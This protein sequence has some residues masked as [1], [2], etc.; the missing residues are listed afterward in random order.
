MMKGDE[1]GLG[2]PIEGGYLFLM[3]C[4]FFVFDFA[5]TDATTVCA[6]HALRTC[7]HRFL[8]SVGF[9]SDRFNGVSDAAS[10]RAVA[11]LTK[12]DGFRGS[13]AIEPSDP[14]C[15]FYSALLRS[16]YKHQSFRSVLSSLILSSCEGEYGHI[17]PELSGDRVK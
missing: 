8:I 13:F 7:R 5:A 2:D 1:F 6:G 11:E 10:L 14:G 15:A 4:L 9:G 16:I 17:R 3:N 12:V